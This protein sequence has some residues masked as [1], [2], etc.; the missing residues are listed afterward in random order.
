MSITQ[1]FV[2]NPNSQ[3]SA[4]K[5]HWIRNC[6]GAAP[7]LTSSIHITYL[8]LALGKEFVFF[9]AKF[10]DTIYLVSFALGVSLQGKKKKQNYENINNGI[11]IDI[12]CV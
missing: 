4:P 6:G 3:L 5:T 1:E 9:W 12:V 11:M 10:L 2:K 7:Q 8:T